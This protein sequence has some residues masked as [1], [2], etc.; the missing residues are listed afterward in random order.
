M[1]DSTNYN[2]RGSDLLFRVSCII[3]ALYI[4]MRVI[5]AGTVIFSPQVIFLNGVALLA[6]ITA[7]VSRLLSN[8]L[9]L[10]RRL[11]LLALFISIAAV[12]IAVIKAG[13]SGYLYPALTLAVDWLADIMIFLA[14]L[15]TARERNVFRLYASMLGA[16]LSITG[17]YALYQKIYALDYL[18]E[19]ALNSG[20]F[21][22]SMRAQGEMIAQAFITRIG[23][24]WVDGGFGSSGIL[25]AFSLLLVVFFFGMTKREKTFYFNGVLF[26]GLAGVAL[27]G[28]IYGFILVKVF[29]VLV[30][31]RLRL[32]R[33]MK[34]RGLLLVSG[35]VGVLT[36]L[37]LIL[38]VGVWLALGGFVAVL[39][40]V[41]LW[42]YEFELLQ[43]RYSTGS[44]KSAEY[45]IGIG[46]LVLL[47][48]LMLVLILAP[49]GSE[50]A[51]IRDIMQ[52]N[53]SAVLY[54]LQ[55]AL[56]AFREAPVVGW[57]LDNFSEIH[58][59]YKCS[60]ATGLGSAG[61]IYAEMLADGGILLCGAFLLLCGVILFAGAVERREH[62]EIGSGQN[63]FKYFGSL[64]IIGAF[65]FSYL[66]VA[67]GIFEHV[68][69]NYFFSELFQSPV[70]ALSRNGAVMPLLVHF[71]VNFILLPG[72]GIYGFKTV[73]INSRELDFTEIEG[74]IRLALGALLLY[75]LVED[76]LYT[77]ALSGIFWVTA[78]MLLARQ[79][80]WGMLNFRPVVSKIL[81]Y[82]VIL[83]GLFWG[84]W[85]IWENFVGSLAE[86]TVLTNTVDMKNAAEL[87]SEI[88][89]LKKVISRSPGNAELY[90]QLGNLRLR[91][92]VLRD[93]V[94]AE[95]YST[96]LD[97]IRK[98]IELRPAAAEYLVN[99]ARALEQCDLMKNTAEIDELYRKAE[100][101]YPLNARFYYLYAR[102]LSAQGR[103]TEARAQ[104][105]TA[106]RLSTVYDRDPATR[107]RSYEMYMVRGIA[108]SSGE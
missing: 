99:L 13:L 20:V 73:W 29:E 98:G 90:I 89:E 3:C 78:G 4:I 104:A 80:A 51:D 35:G 14:V 82:L 34:V 103:T 65:G 83:L 63:R 60:M 54:P 59:G 75:G 61:N 23:D 86:K 52:H 5:L 66:M 42:Y 19:I 101:L 68:G 11:L 62:R 37:S 44:Y 85:V 25:C 32:D 27:A 81:S 43:N 84:T 57:G 88:A 6:L 94:S 2:T 105:K 47:V 40:L 12:G 24:G 15:I 22:D 76:I 102:C 33:S 74:F 18:R 55:A 1:R 107:L 30:L 10:P 21:R 69:A 7:I 48:L 28:S 53:L 95:D 26:L 87:E 41:F 56:R 9:I 31:Y 46:I 45:L 8:G 38:V 92:A 16:G 71:L 36:F 64:L 93:R 70:S 49:T 58:A 91:L 106:I 50:L 67:L 39:A 108:N 79:R 72:I 96:A 97:S 77:P 100:G 17:V